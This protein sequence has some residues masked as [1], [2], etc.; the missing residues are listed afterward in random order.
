[1]LR[2]GKEDEV[3]AR[4]KTHDNDWWIHKMLNESEMSYEESEA[5]FE[6]PDYMCYGA[7]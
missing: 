2:V 7:R 1:M 5:L 3:E 4:Q 6:D